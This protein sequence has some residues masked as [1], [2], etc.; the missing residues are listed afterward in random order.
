MQTTTIMLA[1]QPYTIQ[2]LTIGQQRD[3]QVGVTL[4]PADDP[5]ENVRRA[6]DRNL[7]IIVAGLSKDHP[8]ITMDKLLDMR[9][10]T[11]QERVAAVNAILEFSG[12]VAKETPPGE[13]QAGA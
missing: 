11:P 3:L 13:V 4:P 2:Q 12:L 9:G 6:F 8:Q 10:S 1:G 5:Q 7:A